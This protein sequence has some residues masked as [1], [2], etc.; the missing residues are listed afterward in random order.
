LIILSHARFGSAAREAPD[1]CSVHHYD[2]KN[3]LCDTA[4]SYYYS[5]VALQ[6][7]SAR[8][9]F[10]ARLQL[11][12]TVMCQVARGDCFLRCPFIEIDEPIRGFCPRRGDR[13]HGSAAI[14]T[15][16]VRNAGRQSA[17]I[18]LRQQAGDARPQPAS[19]NVCTFFPFW[20]MNFGTTVG[21]GFPRGIRDRPWRRGVSMFPCRPFYMRRRSVRSKTSRW[22]R[23]TTIA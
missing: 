11:G 8:C 14:W 15:A 17:F 18:C 5:T 19:Q 21:V 23:P 12:G 1:G 4:I 2:E 22:E 16:D 6:T 3:M 9:G 10:V 13:P 20:L 7:N